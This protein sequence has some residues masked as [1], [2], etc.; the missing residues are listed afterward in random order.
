MCSMCGS[1]YGGY[2]N[3][4]AM[5]N[6]TQ[7]TSLKKFTMKQRIQKIIEFYNKYPGYTLSIGPISSFEK[8]IKECK[9]IT[10]HQSYYE[11]LL[12]NSTLFKNSPKDIQFHITVLNEFLKQP[13]RPF[14]RKDNGGLCNNGN[15]ITFSSMGLVLVSNVTNEDAALLSALQDASIAKGKWSGLP[16]YI[17]T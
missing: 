13:N 10:I 11:P 6:L 5:R 15:Y 3:T 12:H 17:S 8:Q 14:N 9:D 1:A 2:S 4:F 7:A 16:I